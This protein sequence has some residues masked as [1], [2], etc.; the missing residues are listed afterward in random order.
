MD[1]Q[2]N[3]LRH[4]EHEAAVHDARRPDDDGAM[5]AARTQD[6]MNDAVDGAQ[7]RITDTVSD[8][9]ATISRTGTNSCEAVGRSLER[10]PITSVLAAFAVGAAIGWVLDRGT[11]RK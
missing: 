10:R 7:R 9:W 4:G 6:R 3:A 11:G 1:N 5:P 8:I 2:E